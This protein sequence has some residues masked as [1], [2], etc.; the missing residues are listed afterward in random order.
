MPI[1]S[2]ALNTSSREMDDNND[3]TSCAIEKKVALS[4]SYALTVR[5]FSNHA[6]EW[7]QICFRISEKGSL[8]SSGNADA[9]K[10]H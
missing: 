7:T 2:R 3:G 1:T 8:P 9:R 10:S 6:L 5:L 4:G